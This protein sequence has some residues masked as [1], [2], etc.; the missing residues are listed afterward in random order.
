MH[1]FDCNGFMLSP[2]NQLKVHTLNGPLGE[3]E[4]AA[5]K[6]AFGGCFEETITDFCLAQ[7]LAHARRVSK[8]ALK[9]EGNYSKPV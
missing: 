7:V 2:E 8:P 6:N 9:S 1:F 3:G 5:L 4:Q